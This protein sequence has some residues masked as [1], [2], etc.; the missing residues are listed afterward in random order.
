MIA[1]DTNVLLRLV[2]DD[3][4]AQVSAVKALLSSGQTCTAP[5]TV[6][7]EF[8]WVLQSRGYE[9]EDIA[10]TLAELLNLPHFECA[11]KTALMQAN[12]DYAAGMDFADALHLAL[13]AGSS[14]FKTFDA[15]LMNKANQL[16]R[17]PPASK[18]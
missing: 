14:A 2:L 6:F 16:K 17:K 18:P 13:C 1:L 15:Q 5:V 3:D 9:R 11:E 8:V 12:E 4:V 7:L 10:H